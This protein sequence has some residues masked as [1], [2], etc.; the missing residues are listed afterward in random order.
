MAKQSGLGMNLYV[1]GTDVSGDTSNLPKI[2]GGP[3]PLDFTA[4][5]KLAF[6]RLGGLRDGHIDWVSYF[7]PT[8]AHPVLSAMP[9]TDIGMM[10]A[11]GTTIGSPGAC[12]LA[13]QLNYDGTRA[14]NGMLTFAVSAVSNGF[15]LEWGRLLTA[16]KRTDTAATNG[17][18]LD[19]TTVSTAF[20]WQAYL[21]VFGFTGT[22]V[23]VKIQ[24]SADNVTFADLAS[25]AFT[26]ITSGTPQA[27]RIAVGGT[28]TVRRYLRASTVTTGGVTSVQFAVTFVR[29]RQAVSF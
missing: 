28:A 23:T 14:T 21:Q 19:D 6:E 24:D 13:K 8:G 18:A 7:N 12:M 27:Q 29:N 4:I 15:G 22:D 10:A 26:Q 9:R 1:S 20:G 2:S 25:G 3:A 11:I 16:G 17:T 5:D